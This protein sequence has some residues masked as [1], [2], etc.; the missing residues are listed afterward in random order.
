[1]ES[2]ESNIDA[3][4][5]LNLVIGTISSVIEFQEFDLVYHVIA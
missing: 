4:M 3:T 2:Q 5:G 1:M